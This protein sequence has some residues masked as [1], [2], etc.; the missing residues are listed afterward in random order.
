MAGESR[1]QPHREDEHFVSYREEVRQADEATNEVKNLI[2]EREALG[3]LDEKV[4]QELE[5]QLRTGAAN[6]IDVMGRL[7]THTGLTDSL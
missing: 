5:N 3:H 1:S 6:P 4:A 7:L 2:I